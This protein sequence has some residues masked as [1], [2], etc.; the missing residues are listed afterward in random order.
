MAV[1]LHCIW[2]DGAQFPTRARRPLSDGYQSSTLAGRIQEGIFLLAL[3]DKP[4]QPL[5]I[6]VAKVRIKT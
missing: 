1:T 4:P 2:T 6:S 3:V 5:L